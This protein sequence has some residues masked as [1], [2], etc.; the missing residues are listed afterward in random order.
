MSRYFKRLSKVLVISFISLYCLIWLLSPTIIRYVINNHGLPKPLSLTSSSTIRY[1]PFTA[2][3]T[4]SDLAMTTNDNNAVLT[5]QALEAELHLHQL[6]FDKIYLAEFSVSEVYIPVTVGESSLNVVGVDLMADESVK[7]TEQ[8]ADSNK[9]KEPFPYQVIIPKFEL[10]DLKVELTHFTQKH[11]IEL[12]SLTLSDILLSESQQHI[13][14][15]VLSKFNQAPIQIALSTKLLQRQG[16]VDIAVNAKNIALTAGQA[17][18]PAD[19]SALDGN[20]SYNSTIK[21]DLDNDK[22]TI[23]INDLLLKIENFHIEQDTIEVNIAEQSI[24]AQNVAILH[25]LNNPLSVTANVDYVIN[26]ISAKSTINSASFAD[27]TQVRFDNVAITVEQDKPQV[28]IDLIEIA[29]SNLSKSH[30]EAI[31]AL[32]AFK[33]LTLDDIEYTPELIV[34]NDIALS[35]LISHVLLD[36]DKNLTT[37][38]LPA[39]KE[40]TKDS[41]VEQITKSTAQN[42]TAKNQQPAENDNTVKLAF[43]LGQFSLLDDAHIDFKDSSVTPH[44]ERNFSIKKLSLSGIDSSKPE[45]KTLFAMHGNSDKYASFDIKGHGFP[46]ALE[47][48]YQLDAVVKELSLPSVSSYIKDALQYEI[49][50]GQLDMTVAAGLTGTKLNGDVELLLRG[51]E[52]TA[53]DDHESGTV[54][55]HAS[56]PF[57]IALGMLKDSNGNVELSLPLSGDTSSPSFGFSGFLT[58]LVKQ[59]TMSAAKD[60]LLTTFVPYANVMKVAMAAGEFALKL[61]INDLSYSA[62]E[63]ELTSDQLEFSRQMSKMLADRSSVNVKLCAIATASD[64]GLTDASQAHQ[65]ENIKRLQKISKQRVEVFKTYMVEQLKVPSARLLLCT[66]QIDTS[67]QAKPRIEFVT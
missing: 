26:D 36:E 5:L 54:T 60:Y 61:R 12:D 59:A 15:N 43:K 31:P 56:V 44:Y 38:V 63:T 7:N 27:I 6:L 39:R 14:L 25:R 23:N 3:L 8:A 51:I 65:A 10:I 41:D 1:N 52:L 40:D 16:Q 24:Q 28:N 21:V 11:T 22:T 48:K 64:I 49:E 45:Q 42:N 58:L 9:P 33:Q 55:D 29:N 66:P 17:F 32:V 47:E 50:S 18:L 57:N 35:G 13:E 62:G 2:H 19:V 67:K 46:F 30:L 37:L 4:I 34:V 53:A 20:V